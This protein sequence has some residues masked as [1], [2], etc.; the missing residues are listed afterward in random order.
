MSQITLL[1]H[2]DVPPLPPR[3]WA[4]F[5]LSR[6]FMLEHSY[7]E[8]GGIEDQLLPQIWKEIEDIAPEEFWKIV[9]IKSSPVD[10]HGDPEIHVTMEKIR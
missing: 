5:R 9:Q 1:Q 10:F 7:D 8:W 6:E 2:G 4:S 3:K